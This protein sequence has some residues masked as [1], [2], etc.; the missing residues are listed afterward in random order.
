MAHQRRRNYLINR[1]LQLYCAFYI[2]ATLL[3]VSL[4]SA[5]CLSFGLWEKVL[6]EFSTTSLG[7]RM[8]IASHIT[9]YE[10]ARIP[11]QKAEQAQRARDFQDV[12]LLSVRDKEILEESLKKNNISLAIKSFFLFIV[13]GIGTIFLTH[14][15]AGPLFRFQKTFEDITNGNLATRVS[16]RKGDQAQ[17]IL[18]Y[19]NAMIGSLD[20]SFS[21]I[22]VLQKKIFE[23][24]KAQKISSATLDEYE[25]RLDEELNRYRT[26]DAFKI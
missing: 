13:I 23:E 17:E 3:I 16:L 4:A 24:L 19:F 26:S 15:I 6:S 11:R 25:Q 20:Y 9:D 21:K 7:N 1:S 5:A 14:K 18:P 12:E 8:Q 2:F 22:K 10:N